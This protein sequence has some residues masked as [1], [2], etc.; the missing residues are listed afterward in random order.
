[1]KN[2]ILAIILG[3]LLIGCGSNASENSNL[4]NSGSKAT[5]AELLET[6]NIPK[7][8]TIYVH[9]YN[10]SGYKRSSVYGFDSTD[11]V[12]D[13]MQEISGLPT[14]QTY[15]KNSS[16]HI[17]AITPYYGDTP[18][19][20]YTDQDIADIKAVTDKYGGGIPRYAQIIAKYAKHVMKITDAQK[21]NIVSVSMGSLVTRWMIEKDIESLASDKKINRWLSIE[22]VIKGNVAASSDRLRDLAG[23]YID[24]DSIDVDHMSYDWIANNLNKDIGTANSPFYKD[25]LMGFISSTNDNANGGALSAFLLL[26][27]H[28][29]P[30]DGYQKLSDTY[31]STIEDSVKYQNQEPTHTLFHDNHLSLKDNTAAWADVMTFLSSKKR[32]KITLTEATVRDI[33]EKKSWYYNY[34]PAE[35]VFASEVFS[36]KVDEKWG[37]KDPISERVYKSAALKKHK[38]RE[39]GETKTLNQ[40]LFNDFVLEDENRLKLNVSGYEIDLDRRYNMQEFTGHRQES[41]GDDSIDIDIKNGTYDIHAKDWDGKIKVEV[42]EYK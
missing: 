17:L 35:I 7:V 33:H 14:L 11:A 20:Y 10:K 40:T 29:E 9:G 23:S 28:F 26:N 8:V 3:F 21:V 32:V 22:G 41:L 5:K 31:F 27:G 12:L 39:D 34:R 30:N 1:M 6:L 37:I 16:T 24:Q 36:P 19:E 18:P 2:I 42:I 13:Q 4:K 38:Y 15:D 25:I